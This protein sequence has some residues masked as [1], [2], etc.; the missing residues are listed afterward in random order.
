MTEKLTLVSI[1]LCPYV[2]RAAITLAEKGVAFD[3]VYVDLATSRIGSRR[4]RLL[5]RF[6]SCVSMT[7]RFSKAA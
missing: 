5:A 2:Q 1:H 7:R 6:R 3:K 4:Y